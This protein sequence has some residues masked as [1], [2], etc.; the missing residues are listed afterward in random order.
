MHLFHEKFVYCIITFTA[1]D[2]QWGSWC[3]DLQTAVGRVQVYSE[4]AS[5]VF[6]DPVK[7]PAAPSSWRKLQSL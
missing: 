3:K 4:A 5:T 7:A 2:D 1:G 6:G